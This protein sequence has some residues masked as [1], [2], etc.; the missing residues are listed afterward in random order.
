MNNDSNSF[1]NYADPTKPL[2]LN[3]TDGIIHEVSLK[4]SYDKLTEGEKLM[5]AARILGMNHLPVDMHTFLFD[6]YFLGADSITNHGTAIF[7]F[8]Q[9]KFDQIFPTPVSTRT[10]YISFGVCFVL[11]FMTSVLIAYSATVPVTMKCLHPISLQICI[12]CTDIGMFFNCTLISF[13]LS[14]VTPFHA[15]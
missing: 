9:D 8:W 5:V 12:A 2:D 14:D 3:Y 11:T 6:D 15:K 1:I 7:K 4:D 10:P 13:L